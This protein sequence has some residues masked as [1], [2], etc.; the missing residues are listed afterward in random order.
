MEMEELYRLMEEFRNSGIGKLEFQTADFKIKLEMPEPKAA[1]APPAIVV[2][3]AGAQTPAAP[4][5][6]QA[7]APAPE[8]AAGAYAPAAQPAETGAFIR[9]PLVGTFY[10]APGEG[11]A[12]YVTAGAKVRKGDTVCIVEAMKM[13]NEV[14]ADC[15]CVIEEVLKENGSAAGF[16][17]P[18]F[19][20]REI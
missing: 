19:R 3:A 5:A 8:A 7:Q 16:E 10:A 1:A 11:S 2:Q 14:K 9:S 15:D 6:L 20:I 18:L 4:A 13:M 12:P 17:E